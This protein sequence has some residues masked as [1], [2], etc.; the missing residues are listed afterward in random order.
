MVKLITVEGRTYK[1]R[2]DLT[3]LGFKHNKTQRK[4]YVDS[5]N[6][7]FFDSVSEHFKNIPT[8]RVSFIP[9]NF[10]RSS[11]YRDEFFENNKGIFGHGKHYRCAY[12][13]KILS[14][15]KTTVDH[16][17][18]IKKI[19]NKARYRLYLKI[20]THSKNV[21][22]IKNLAPACDRCNKKKSARG[23]IW[24][25]KGFSGK[26]PLDITLRRLLIL[27][28]CTYMFFLLS[29]WFMSYSLQHKEIINILERLLKI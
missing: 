24:I 1:Y 13:G 25:I 15:D 2:D 17:I 5:D 21:N 12:C 9:S 18:P 4:W 26:K 20:L 3:E 19:Q 16:I 22:N 27:F 11:F 8:I 6:R 23:G 28:L 14:T 29:C 7:Y 10:Y